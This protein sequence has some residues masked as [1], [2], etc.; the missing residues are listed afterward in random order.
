ML[1]VLSAQLCGLPTRR[2]RKHAAHSP[3]EK[4]ET[5]S[6][7][8]WG[9]APLA[10][11]ALALLLGLVL[12]AEGWRAERAERFRLAAA[13]LTG[14]TEPAAQGRRLAYL[15]AAVGFTPENGTLQCNLAEAY[16]GQFQAAVQKATETSQV[17]A[18]PQA[19]QE[20]LVREQ[21]VP[22]LRHYLV[23]RD[24]C[25][26]L[27]HAQMG[28]AAIAS[29]L[30]KADDVAFYLTRVKWLRPADAGLWYRAGFLELHDGRPE[31]A[32]QS[33]HQSLTCSERFLGPIV[34]ESA[35]VLQPE[36]ILNKIIPDSPRLLLLAG[37]VH[38]PE[39]EPLARRQPF[40]EKGLAL[41]DRRAA[42][43]NAEDLHT[44]GLIYQELGQSARAVTDLR[45]ALAQDPN[46]VAWRCE[47]ARFLHQEGKIEESCAEARVILVQ[48]PGNDEARKILTSYH[49]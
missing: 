30:R 19:N 14:S 15:E 43:P 36:Q 35:K 21:L 42:S 41:L 7:S 25:P 4:S 2:S 29:R 13:Y 27:P 1:T 46:Q 22:A 37:S 24:L 39:L 31:Q 48:Q 33:W 9:L 3:S 45:A 20:P 28:L 16:L 23:A 5:A 44:R 12:L 38:C 32:W 8:L 17:G 49:H 11:S 40:L 10:G 6:A 34:S 26:L 18:T 47:L